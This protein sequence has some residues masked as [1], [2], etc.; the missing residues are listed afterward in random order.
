MATGLNAPRGVV[1]D[2]R[3]NR[4]LVAEA[5]V[6][7]GDTGPCGFAERG[8]P[9]CLGLTGSVFEYSERSAQGRRIVTG[10]PSAGIQNGLSVV[11][12]L[13][14]LAITG[15][16]LTAVFGLL[17]TKA[18]RDSLGPDAATMGQVVTINHAGKVVPRGDVTA[19]EDQYFPGHIE[20]DPYGIQTGPYGT[21]VANAG[22]PDSRGNDLL[23]VRPNGAISELAQFP[24]RQPAA[25][26]T[27]TIES[28]PT[29]VMQ[30][31][32][33]AFYVGELTGAPWYTGEARVYRVV[34]GQPATI[35]AQGF[36]NI[37]DL[38][39]DPQGRLVVLQTS[40]NN[41]FD[42]TR[43]GALVRVERDGSHTTLASAGLRNPG[44]VAVAGPS[45]FYV[46]LGT[47]TSGGTGELALV[48]LTS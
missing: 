31:P 21:V 19:F 37:I 15:D 5:G 44:G 2:Q 30:G 25:D 42:V 14:D 12:G 20:S 22:G 38:T 16:K 28:V 33:G 10:L 45:S 48:Q 8:L 9:F 4:V 41:P 39:F 23:L 11:I 34:P 3:R 29:T 24:A 43:D 7:A 17:G 32:D 13:H 36:T 18:Y 1:Y 27:D 35:Y 6:L 40:T 47:A 46:T 26:P